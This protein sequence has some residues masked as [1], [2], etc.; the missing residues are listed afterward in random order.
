MLG[1][2]L[3][4]AR[5]GTAR[6]GTVRLGT[7]WLGGHGPAQECM[8]RPVAAPS[9]P[10]LRRTARLGTAALPSPRPR[11]GQP[12]AA[13]A[14]P[15]LPADGVPGAP[16]FLPAAAPFPGPRSPRRAPASTGHRGP[17]RPPP[18]PPAHLLLVRP[19]RQRGREGGMGEAREAGQGAR[20]AG[21]QR[22]RCYRDGR[23]PPLRTAVASHG[24]LRLA[25][26]PF[27]VAPRS[28]HS[29]GPAWRAVPHMAPRVFARP[30]PPAVPRP[31]AGV[32]C[33]CGGAGTLTRVW[34]RSWVRSRTSGPALAPQAPRRGR[35][36]HR[37]SRNGD[38]AG[39]RRRHRGH[40]AT[41]LG[42]VLTPWLPQ[43]MW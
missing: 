3:S 8:A 34:V 42:P 2:R 21:G 41:A 13:R 36:G 19:G 37:G 10:A 32:P 1:R 31:G 22:G 43:T 27:R 16:R 11:L 29:C 18:P 5:H 38:P 40:P 35:W 33:P 23:P 30:W 17:R 7:A 6:C 15:A 39:S 12:L 25:W 14:A 24:R 28:L 26:P 9:L 4:T 20:A